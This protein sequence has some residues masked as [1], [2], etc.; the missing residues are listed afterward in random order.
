LFTK[1]VAL[2]VIIG[3]VLGKAI[4][5]FG[6]AY[7][8]ARLT[9]AELARGLRWSEVFAVAVL[10]GVGFTVALLISDLA[11]PGQPDLQHQAKAAVLVGSLLAAVLATVLLRGRLRS[12]RRGR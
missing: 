6:G 10:G 11:F 9:R 12:R 1:P 4:G 3:L 5:I 8:T 2:G 7:L